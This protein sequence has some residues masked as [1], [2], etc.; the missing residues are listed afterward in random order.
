MFQNDITKDRTMIKMTEKE[1]LRLFGEY[2]LIKQHNHPLF[3]F[4]KDFYTYN[5]ICAQNF[6]KYYNRYQQTKDTMVLLPQK[7][8][9]KWGNRRP[10]LYMEQAIIEER[11]QGLNKYEIYEVLKNRFGDLTPSPSSIYRL[12]VRHQK[13][14]LTKKEKQEKR[15]YMK[16]KSGE[17][18]HTDCYDLPVGLIANDREKRYL[19]AL[20]DDHSRVAWCELLDDKTSLSAMFGIMRC[21]KAFKV[22]YSIEFLEIM[23]DNG[24][25]FGSG[26]RSESVLKTNPFKRLL[27][28]LGIKHRNT[29]PYK[30]QT[31]G[32]VERFW[33]TLNED[34]IEDA[35]YDSVDDFRKELFKYM[36]YYNEYRPHQGINNKIPAIFNKEKNEN[37]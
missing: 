26:S 20:L 4:V 19:I 6:L 21:L 14:V 16:E 36:I 17:L 7:R 33:K 2:D 11:E 1:W 31:N 9:P 12:L 28:E 13:N 18:G 24:A 22:N 23:S 30:P 32:K 34:L 3:R 10:E 29:K 5:E 15:R 27:H 8:G 37:V 25:E 35:T